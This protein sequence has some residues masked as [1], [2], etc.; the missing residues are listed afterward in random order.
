MTTKKSSLNPRESQRP[1]RARALLPPS[2]NDDRM[3]FEEHVLSQMSAQDRMLERI[4]LSSDQQGKKIDAIH[5]AIYDPD[6][7]LYGRV[8]EHGQVIT[9]TSK[10]L[11]WFVGLLIASGL[12]GIGK[13]LYDFLSGHIH[14]TP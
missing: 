1:P 6:T 13:V 10:G 5:V 3:S 11:T 4:A 9:K 14:F 2:F 8:K 12:G 7:G